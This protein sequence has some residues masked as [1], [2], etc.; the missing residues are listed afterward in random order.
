M[1]AIIEATIQENKALPT[2][3]TDECLQV[4]SLKTKE[5]ILLNDAFKQGHKEIAE[6]VL[7][8]QAPDGSGRKRIHI[9]AHTRF[10]KS[11]AI[12]TAVAIRASMKKEPWAIVAPTKEQ[13]Q[14]IMDYVIWVAVNDPI[15][16]QLLKTETARALQ[17]ELMTQRRSRDHITFL[18]GGEVRTYTSGST[19]GFGCANVVLDE[20]GLIDNDTESRIFRMLGDHTDN[21]YVKIGNP[22][23]SMDVDGTPHHFFASYED[24]SYYAINIDYKRGIAEGRLTEAYVKEVAKKPNFDILFDNLFPDVDKQDKDGYY[25]LFT[26]RMLKKAMIEAGTL[27]SVG[28]E[29]LGGDPADAGENEAVICVRSHNLAKIPFNST[30]TD[31]LDFASKIE[32]HGSRV[33]EWY[34]DKQ[35]VG[36]GTVRMLQK[37]AQ[38]NRKLTPINSGEQ[39][40]DYIKELDQLACDLY[41][42]MRAYMFFKSSEWLN[43]GGKLVIKEGVEWRQL[44]SVKWKNNKKGK[45]QIISKDELRKRKIPDLGVADAFS[46]TFGIRKKVMP[47]NAQPTGGIAPYYP[48]I[49]QNQR[50]M[51]PAARE[52]PKPFYPKIYGL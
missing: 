7:T 39:V 21:F 26:Q 51:Q 48:K 33:S 35:G 38:S 2:P 43:Q 50:P 29:R 44:L 23:E 5:G 11:L 30:E 9:M 10:G 15:I 34:V 1:E 18:G 27:E 40:P 22:W 47:I 25:P 45:I 20:A 13:A 3:T 8:R 19:M 17:A 49:Q 41:E 6:C 14:I 31:V 28:L 42:N 52:M 46:M 24:P 36:S 16:K 32:Q 12:G 37:N 4:F